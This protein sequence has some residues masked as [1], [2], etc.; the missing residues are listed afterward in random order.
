LRSILDN[1]HSAAHDTAQ[2][3]QGEIRKSAISHGWDKKVVN[4]LHVRFHDN[5][6]NVY[7]HDKY[8]GAALTH[9]FGNESKRP[10]AAI[11]KYS[12]TPTGAGSKFIESLGEH[13]GGKK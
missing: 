10:T 6:F 3:I 9:E 5:K 11:R 4:N 7:V 8:M 13:M 12:N 2:Y 1:L